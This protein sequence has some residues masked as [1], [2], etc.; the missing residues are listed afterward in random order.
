MFLLF[1][2]WNLEFVW[3]LEFGLLDYYA[4]TSR[5]LNRLYVVYFYNKSSN[6]A[7]SRV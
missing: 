6:I 3:D 1:D 4:L 7:F 5:H 2:H